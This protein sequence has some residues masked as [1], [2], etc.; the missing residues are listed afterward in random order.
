M[1][2]LI[3]LGTLTA[4]AYSTVHL[5]IGG[6][7]FYDTTVVIMAF[8]VLGRYFEARATGRASGA[9]RALLELGAKQARVLSDGQER[10]VAVEEVGVGAIVLVRP[11]EKIPVDGEVLEGR[12]AVDESLLTGESLPV[13]KAPGERV[14]GATI[15]PDGALTIRA[16]AVGSN[17]ALA[18]IVK[19]I[20]GAQSG[21]APVQSLADRVAGIFVPAVLLIAAGTFVGW[22]LAA[23]DATQGLVSAVAVPIIACPCAMGLATP[24][25]IMTGTGR[26]AALGVLIKSAEVLESSRRIDMVVFD[27]TGTLTTGRLQLR[28]VIAGDGED[29]DELLARAASVEASSEHPIAAAIVQ[30]AHD[31][32]MPIPVAREFKSSTGR[33]ACAIVD[34]T[35]V[36]VGRSG[37]VAEEG[38]DLNEQFDKRVLEAEQSGETVVFIAWEGRPRG[39]LVVGDAPKPNAA[40]TVSR[41]RA[42]GMEVAMITGDNHRTAVAV[43][44][45]V[46]VDAVLAEVLPAD[47]VGEVRRLQQQGK[48]VA[49]VGDGINDAPAL[50]QADLG[51]A[52]GTGTDVAIESSD[53]TLISGDIA[54][55]LTALAL[56]RRTLRTIHQNLGWAFGYNVAAIPLAAL[57]LLPPIAAGAIMAASSVSVVSNSLR[58][59]RFSPPS[60][61]PSDG[62]AD[63]HILP[64]AISENPS[65][66]A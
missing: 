62:R 10:L 57:G 65:L 42:M 32:G 19:L 46:G 64:V 15:N 26:G 29:V 45:R 3:A 59:F 43:A 5:L 23:G 40:E 11:G 4:F 6:D 55:V 27:K 20:E 36:R 31:R 17:T 28:E 58:L 63:P 37:F 9:I 56:A 47:K 39:A 41:L 53:L 22:W 2:T 35:P 51:V 13:E 33:G 24:T 54:G 50:V 14:A 18:Q 34:D 49:M 1:D 30:G 12:S 7:L 61:Q 44:S 21:K 60:A 16:T 48:R 38:F 66:A 25:A 52:I 8:I